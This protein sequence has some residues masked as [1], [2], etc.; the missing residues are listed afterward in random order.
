MQVVRWRPHLCSRERFPTE[1][2]IS[3]KR[4]CCLVVFV[5]E[6]PLLTTLAGK[7]NING[8]CLPAPVR[9]RVTSM[10]SISMD[11]AE[12]PSTL[13]AARTR[14]YAGAF[15]STMILSRVETAALDACWSL[16]MDCPNAALRA[17]RYAHRTPAPS[18]TAV[19]C[20]GATPIR[21]YARPGCTLP[22]EQ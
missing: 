11:L 6:C 16:A 1:Q 10:S 3:K 4:K 21:N 8:I 13:S 18:S 20:L 2:V 9:S 7:C 14:V 5:T 12:W 15:W 19:A 22:R 17:K